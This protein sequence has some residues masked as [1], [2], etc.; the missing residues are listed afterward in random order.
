MNRSEPDLKI[1]TCRPASK[2]ASE[3]LLSPEIENPFCRLLKSNLHALC[4]VNKRK[5]VNC[6]KIL[7]VKHFTGPYPDSGQGPNMVSD[8]KPS[9]N[10]MLESALLLGTLIKEVDTSIGYIKY[11]SSRENFQ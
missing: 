4:S 6:Y 1:R 3:A 11:Q 9:V 10:E 7:S 5:T 2:C 8:C